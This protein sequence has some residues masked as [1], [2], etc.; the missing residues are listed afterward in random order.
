MD[1]QE[2]IGMLAIIE[3]RMDARQARMESMMDAHQARME[4]MMNVWGETLDAW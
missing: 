2:I 4:A 3:A 1:T